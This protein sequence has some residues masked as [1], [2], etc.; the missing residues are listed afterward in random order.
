MDL[1]CIIWFEDGSAYT[2]VDSRDERATLT[3]AEMLYDGYPV[4]ATE[5]DVAAAK[6]NVHYAISEANL[7]KLFGVR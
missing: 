3:E 4:L 6:E 5:D 7:Y 2:L 1:Y